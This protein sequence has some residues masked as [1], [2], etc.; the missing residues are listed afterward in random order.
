MPRRRYQSWSARWPALLALSAALGCLPPLTSAEGL[1]C[2]EGHP[3]PDGLRCDARL[4]T[5]QAAVEPDVV[6]FTADFEA[7]VG[8]WIGVPSGALSQ[9]VDQWRGGAASLKVSARDGAKGVG[10]ETQP[11]QLAVG[12]GL[13]CATGWA[14]HG[15]GSAALSL[16]LRALGGA[17]GAAVIAQSASTDP[18]SSVTVPASGKA[19]LEL[20][21]ALRVDAATATDVRLRLDYQNPPPADFYLDDVKVL[22]TAAAACP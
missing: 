16:T 9:A 20:R 6:L 14:R 22:R 21:A 7:G 19:F 11:G 15:L 3:C 5:A 13:Y 10:V 4:C 8:P 17:G 2:D 18:G 1:P 12:S